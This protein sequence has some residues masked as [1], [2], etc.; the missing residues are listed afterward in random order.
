MSTTTPA[1]D[2]SVAARYRAAAGRRDGQGVAGRSRSEGRLKPNGCSSIIVL[3][4]DHIND[5]PVIRNGCLRRFVLKGPLR[6]RLAGNRKI[7]WPDLCPCSRQ[8]IFIGRGSPQSDDRQ[9]RGT[10]IKCTV[11]DCDTV[12]DV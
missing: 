8:T 2:V 11:S 9:F 5:V 7:V 1:I 3:T 10:P 4:V 6:N 12:A